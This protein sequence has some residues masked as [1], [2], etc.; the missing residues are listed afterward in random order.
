MTQWYGSLHNRLEENQQ[1]CEE[2]KVGT[3]ATIY[4][5]SDRHAYEVI[6]VR[7][8][9]HVT[10]REY[11]HK[12]VG[13]CHM[14]NN[15]ELISNES[16]PT[17]DLVKRGKYWYTESVCTPEVAKEALETKDLQTLVWLANNGINAEEVVANGK[18]VKR[19]HKKNISFGRGSYY[20]DYE[21]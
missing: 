5:W 3:G 1:W 20:Y 13:E 16:N 11:D 8:Q 4:S 21:F 17:M 15:W 18:P 12:H 9:K 7:D 19:Y 14:D 2:I 10:I 6:E